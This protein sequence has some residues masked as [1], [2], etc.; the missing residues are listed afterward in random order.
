MRKNTGGK[1]IIFADVLFV[2]SIILLVLGVSL[3][4]AGL[5]VLILEEEAAAVTVLLLCVSAY[6][7]ALTTYLSSLFVRGY[8]EMVRNSNL[9]AQKADEII[10]RLPA[11]ETSEPSVYDQVC[12]AV[13]ESIK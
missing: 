12:S 2:L 13:Q 5:V 6:G 9:L 3:M 8:G 7:S 10:D 4:I 1:I 11:P